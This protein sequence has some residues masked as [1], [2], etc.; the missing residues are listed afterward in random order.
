ML[1]ILSRFFKQFQELN[2]PVR[3]PNRVLSI[4]TALYRIDS[5][6]K[7]ILVIFFRS[8][9]RARYAQR[10]TRKQFSLFAYTACPLSLPLKFTIDAT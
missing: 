5:V 3:I 4:E 8:E 1:D 7:T 6:A 9:E 2:P 10:S